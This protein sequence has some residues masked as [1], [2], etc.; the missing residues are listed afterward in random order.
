MKYW[1]M[2]P[3]DGESAKTCRGQVQ[4]A[5][6]VGVT[7]VLIALT[8][9]YNTCFGSHIFPDRLKISS[10]KRGCLRVVHTYGFYLLLLHLLLPPHPP[11]RNG[12]Y[13][14]IRKISS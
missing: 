11:P 4:K 7:R 3:E 5:A 10:Q 13:Q 1:C 12:L 2:F 14:L 8:Y 9:I 6:F